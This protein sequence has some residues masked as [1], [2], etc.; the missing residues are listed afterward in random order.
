[1]TCANN[2]P[3]GP[4]RHRRIQVKRGAFHSDT[5]RVKLQ[6]MDMRTASVGVKYIQQKMWRK[7][8]GNGI[9]EAAG[10]EMHW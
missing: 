10:A 1:M 4:I 6:G 5:L 3:P 2:W 9:R 8:Q 7:K